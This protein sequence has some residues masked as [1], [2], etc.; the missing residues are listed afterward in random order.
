MCFNV[1]GE[2]VG[3]APAVFQIMPGALNF[4]IK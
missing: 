1:D 4:I 2:F 3:N